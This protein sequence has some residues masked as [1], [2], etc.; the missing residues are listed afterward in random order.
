MKTDYYIVV[1][2]DGF[3]RGGENEQAALMTEKWK[4]FTRIFNTEEAAW[5]E[6]EKR[7]PEECYVV[8]ISLDPTKWKKVRNTKK[9]KS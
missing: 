9:V 6:G 5:K 7:F 4:P 1:V 2:A 3:S 8:P